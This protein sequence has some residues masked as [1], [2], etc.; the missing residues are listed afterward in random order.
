MKNGRA[1]VLTAVVCGWGAAAAPHGQQAGP[2]ASAAAPAA[3][4]GPKLTPEE[5]FEFQNK[6]E[7]PGSP[8]AGRPI[9]E[10]QCAAC[11]RF[12]ALGREV[13]PDL[14]TVASRFKKKDL[15]ES[16]LWPSKVI[17]DQYK[18]EMFE[19]K[20]GKVLV[21]VVAREDA[22]RV[23]LTTAESPERPVPVPKAQIAERAEGTVSLMPEGLLEGHSQADIANLLTF[24]L[25]APPGN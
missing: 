8:E 7:Q 9:F 15:L 12:G 11:H 2:Q 18:A 23:H 20:D 21:G 19:L 1:W 24:L 17:S 6:Q 4:Q 5:I 25:T 14:T 16:I 13:G 3:A 10:K 22:L